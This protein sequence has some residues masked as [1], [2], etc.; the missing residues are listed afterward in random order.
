M[1]SEQ[2]FHTFAKI[3]RDIIAN[4][5]TRGVSEKDLFQPGGPL[6]QKGEFP[7]VLAGLPTGERIVL[8]KKVAKLKN[9]GPKK[10]AELFYEISETITRFSSQILVLAGEFNHRS[11][12]RLVR[13]HKFDQ[14]IKKSEVSVLVIGGPHISVGSKKAKKSQ[15]AFQI[16]PILDLAQRNLIRLYLKEDKREVGHFLVGTHTDIIVLQ[17]DPH[18]EYENWNTNLY[19]DDPIK[20]NSLRNRFND[21]LVSKQA[22]LW[23]LNLDSIRTRLMTMRELKELNEKR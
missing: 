15:D 3:R 23:D 14:L 21:L 19:Y 5:Y 12:R 11:Y 20:C 17:E 4:A 2:S 13:D 22:F 16:N 6:G 1:K 18:L 7:S 10:A 8:K 9:T